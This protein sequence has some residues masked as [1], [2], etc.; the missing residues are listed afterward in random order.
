MRFLAITAIMLVASPAFAQQAAPPFV[1]YTINQETHNKMINFLGEQPA[2]I[3][4]PL[5]QMLGE[6][7]QQAVRDKVAREAKALSDGKIPK[8]SRAPDQPQE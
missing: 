7:Q 8:E 5:I 4:I 6:I 3:A 1:P 2:K